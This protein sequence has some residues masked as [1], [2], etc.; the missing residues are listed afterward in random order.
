M[1]VEAHEWG[2]CPVK[3]TPQSPLA[4]PRQED[5]ARSWPPATQ[6]TEPRQPAPSQLCGEEARSGPVCAVSV[7]QAHR[8]HL[9]RPRWNPQNP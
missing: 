9:F 4:L 2:G 3:D 8:N 7:Q 6:K 1:R 5:T